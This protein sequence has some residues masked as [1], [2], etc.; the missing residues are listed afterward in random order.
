MQFRTTAMS[1]FLEYF[2][3]TRIFQYF[4]SD[5][6]APL[7]TPKASYRNCSGYSRGTPRSR[8]GQ[9]ARPR[10]QG[11][12]QGSVRRDSLVSLPHS[13]THLQRFAHR[14]NG[15]KIDTPGSGVPPIFEWQIASY[16]MPPSGSGSRSFR[17]DRCRRM[18][19][20]ALDLDC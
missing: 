11:F 3:L 6:A 5:S 17:S 8:G 7:T 2:K 14:A 10:M 12:R 19:A 13:R 1:L 15:Q 4:H 18:I 16:D 20:C 9:P